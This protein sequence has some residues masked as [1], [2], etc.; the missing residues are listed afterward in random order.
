MIIQPSRG[1]HLNSWSRPNVHAAQNN[2]AV[3]LC[4]NDSLKGCAHLDV[5][6][7]AHTC[8]SNERTMALRGDFCGR[9]TP[10]VSSKA[11]RGS[12]GNADPHPH[13]QPTGATPFVRHITRTN[14]VH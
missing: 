5:I 7:S 2:L 6:N 9:C 1:I 10:R 12:P 3:D 14:P 11:K 13:Q 4:W 8:Y